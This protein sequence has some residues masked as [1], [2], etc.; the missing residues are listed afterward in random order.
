MIKGFPVSENSPFREVVL[1]A[2]RPKGLRERAR[3]LILGGWSAMQIRARLAE[4]VG[5][6]V[7]AGDFEEASFL[8]ERALVEATRAELLALVHEGR[9]FRSTSS[10]GVELRSKGHRQAVLD[11]FRLT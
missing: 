10:Y 5:E 6:P 9:V 2:L 8:R 7:P 3:A 1:A 4:P 11:V